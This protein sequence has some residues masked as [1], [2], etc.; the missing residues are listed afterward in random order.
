MVHLSAGAVNLV[1]FN[2]R[3][4]S[5]D[6]TYESEGTQVGAARDYRATVSYR[7]SAE[8]PLQTQVVGVNNPLNVG[9]ASVFLVGHGYAPHFIVKD[10]T[11]K[12]VFDDAVVFLPQDPNFTSQG[13][14][15]VPDTT[16]QL[17][18]NGVFAPTGVVTKERGPHSLFPQLIDP[19]VFLSV[20]EGDLGLDAGIPQNVYQ[21]STAKLKRVGLEELSPGE[22]WKLPNGLGTLEFVDVVQFATF[23]IASDPGQNWA[24][25]GAIL[26]IV[27]VIAGLYVQRRRLWI[28]VFSDGVEVAIMSR[29]EDARLS[30]VLQDFVHFC[31]VDLHMT[32]CAPK[33][34]N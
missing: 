23:N 13:V 31:E 1:P 19:M 2:I 26:A 18:F 7:E 3:L 9:N 10:K 22:S 17:G 12:V 27:G 20:W 8:S 4:D 15:K 34:R 21:L 30:E 29:Y 11:G 28:R 6:V 16:P 32:Q 33:E 14:I 25:V 5:L 24:L